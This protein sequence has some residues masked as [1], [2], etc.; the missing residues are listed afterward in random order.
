MQAAWG[1][2]SDADIYFILHLFDLFES[3]PAVE[4]VNLTSD[5]LNQPVQEF[6]CAMLFSLG[7]RQLVRSTGN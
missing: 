5:L 2:F 6:Y 1:V 3:N 4:K 7:T